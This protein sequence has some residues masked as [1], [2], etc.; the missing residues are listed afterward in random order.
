MPHG[1]SRSLG[2]HRG[3]TRSSGRSH[4]DGIVA[5]FASSRAAIRRGSAS[6]PTTVWAPKK[7][8]PRESEFP[9]S[10]AMSELVAGRECQC[11]D[12]PA[13]TNPLRVRTDSLDRSVRPGSP[14][15]TTCRPCSR[16]PQSETSNSTLD[17]PTPRGT[18]S[19]GDDR[20][21]AAA[22]R[23]KRSESTRAQVRAKAGGVWRDVAHGGRWLERSRC[24]GIRWSGRS[25]APQRRRLGPSIDDRSCPEWPEHRASKRTQMVRTTRMGSTEPPPDIRP[26]PR[27]GPSTA[28]RPLDLSGTRTPLSDRRVHIPELEANPIRA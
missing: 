19:D 2:Y 3:V 20:S 27:C 13:T 24:A 18:R 7:R 5:P 14:A 17:P 8:S 12:P 10:I 21:V 6:T 16:S 23:R 1:T 28:E 4:P 9:T 11:F 15:G 22:W 25:A 26:R